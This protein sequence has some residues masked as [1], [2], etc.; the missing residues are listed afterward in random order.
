VPLGKVLQVLRGSYFNRAGGGVV[1]LPPHRWLVRRIDLADGLQPEAF[2]STRSTSEGISYLVD[3]DV[4]RAADPDDLWILALQPALSPSG[5][6]DDSDPVVPP[7]G[8][9][10]ADRLWIDLKRNRWAPPVPPI[11]MV[12]SSAPAPVN[13]GLEK[14]SMFPVPRWNSWWKANVGGH[15]PRRKAGNHLGNFGVDGVVSTK[16]LRAAFGTLADPWEVQV[17]FQWFTLFVQFQHYHPL[18]PHQRTLAVPPGLVVSAHGAPRP[19]LPPDVFDSETVGG[20]T[21][22][23]D[24]GTVH[25]IVSR[26]KEQ[27]DD[28]ELSFEAPPQALLTIDYKKSPGPREFD[29]RL[30]AID[31]KADS[32]DPNARY[33]V[34]RSWHSSGWDARV[35]TD[36]RAPWSTMRPTPTPAANAGLLNTSQS[37][38]L[39]F[40]LDD[41]VLADESGAVLPDPPANSRVTL[42]NH[43]LAVREPDIAGDRPQLWQEKL[44]RNYLA[45]ENGFVSKGDLLVGSTRLIHLE[46]R[47]FD[48]REDRIDGAPGAQLC[49][50]ARKAWENQHPRSEHPQGNPFMLLPLGGSAQ[51]NGTAHVR[52]IDAP[53]VEHAVKS[54]LVKLVHVLVYFGCS[55]QPPTLTAPADAS[56]VAFYNALLDAEMKW[57]QGHP[58]Y[59]G[60]PKD[61]VLVPESGSIQSGMAVGRF[62]FFFAPRL[63]PS[64]PNDPLL[65][66][67][68]RGALTGAESHARTP[69]QPADIVASTD[70]LALDPAVTDIDG[71]SHPG[72]A[73][74]HESGHIAGMPDEYVQQQRGL[75]GLV[76]PFMDGGTFVRPPRFSQKF[77]D[78][79]DGTRPFWTDS[80]AQMYRNLCPRLRSYWPI[81]E[82]VNHMPANKA[83]PNAPYLVE[84]AGFPDTLRYKLPDVSGIPGAN[85]K[86]SPWEPIL[87]KQRIGKSDILLFRLGDDEGSVSTMF[88]STGR[89]AQQD[90]LSG[91]AVV[92]TYYWFNYDTA[93]FPPGPATAT[94]A[95][96][97][98]VIFRYY[99]KQFMTQQIL[100][101]MKFIVEADPTA[102]GKAS[103][104]LPRLAVLF[105]PQ[106]KFGPAVE[107]GQGADATGPHVDGIHA[108]IT[109]EVVGSLTPNVENTLLRDNPPDPV[110]LGAS[111][112]DWRLLRYA[113]GA[114]H[115]VAT[116]LPGPHAPQWLPLTMEPTASEL[117]PLADAIGTMLGDKPLPGLTTRTIRGM[118]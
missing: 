25:V 46:G 92:R 89:I 112:V 104:P 90:R 26:T 81:V 53:H 14:R 102:A 97:Y 45:A 115:R 1:A 41:I 56:D 105:M 116:G 17:D 12:A 62:R 42:F 87:P 19:F 4:L 74:W 23:H 66:T 37:K 30:V 93:S 95:P 96:W 13:P 60:A 69:A 91:L 22:I 110:R 109:L 8:V 99:E 15:S 11:G 3:N 52:L 50:G 9:E 101:I 2:E 55:V 54:T 88:R 58:S 83:L 80:H 18:A 78:R 117:Q 113:I 57:S 38:P 34:P 94:M 75:A 27:C 49:L 35:G 40:H 108:D 64:T 43:L 20:G 100:P 111:D 24:D 61:Y 63:V 6:D 71:T 33:S 29:K 10:A 31:P 85:V 65:V 44:A 114:P 76:T 21:A 28:L 82:L 51:P 48:V 67:L 68:K 106:F 70:S 73:F 7:G 47:F 5:T 79:W 32:G 77:G 84:H 107:N 39:I 98:E 36:P 118:P 59:P 72:Q 86:A 103:L 16:E